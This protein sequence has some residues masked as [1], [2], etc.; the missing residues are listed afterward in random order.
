MLFLLVALLLIIGILL[1][2]KSSGEPESESSKRFKEKNPEAWARSNRINRNLKIIGIIF[3]IAG[4]VVAVICF[5][6]Y[7]ITEVIAGLMVTAVAYGTIWFL[8]IGR[9]KLGETKYVQNMVHEQAAREAE[10]Q[11]Q[12]IMTQ[13]RI[14][15]TTGAKPKTP[16]DLANENKKASVAKRAAAGAI[17]AGE[18]GAIIGAASAIN[19]NLKNKDK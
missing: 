17:I 11:A 2:P 15:N 7:D 5:L 3:I 12:Q 14:A 10:L 16:T 18:T 9:F 8:A 13:A 1:I 4:I 19:E 6:V